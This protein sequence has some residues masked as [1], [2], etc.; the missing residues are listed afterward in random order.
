MQLL[1]I[2]KIHSISNEGPYNFH[3]MAFY[4]FKK[5]LQCDDSDGDSKTPKSVFDTFVSCSKTQYMTTD[6]F[7]AENVFI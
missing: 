2:I 7:Y 3:S 6:T 1:W 5:F 4:G